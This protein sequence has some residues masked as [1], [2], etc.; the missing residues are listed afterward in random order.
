MSTKPV[1]FDRRYGELDQVISA[2]LGRSAA[3]APARPSAT[4]PSRR[5][6]WSSN[7]RETTLRAAGSVPLPMS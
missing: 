4:T 3:D 7:G 2:Y 6:E 5:W 1:D